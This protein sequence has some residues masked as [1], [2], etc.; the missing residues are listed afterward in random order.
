LRME[1]SAWTKERLDDLAES[2]RTGFAR[3]DQDLRDVRV[4]LREE[5]GAV[6]GELGGLR[7]EMGEGFAGLRGEI[8]D[9]RAEF[10][11]VMFRVGGGVIIALIGVIGV[12]LARGV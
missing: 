11:S 7:Q 4:E 10:R 2:S 9:L 5:I 12:L 8:S 6:R 3:L 1:S